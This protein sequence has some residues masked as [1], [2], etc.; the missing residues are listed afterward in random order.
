M[1]DDLP[2]SE[3]VVRSIVNE[4]LKEMGRKPEAK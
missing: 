1:S 4:V 3:F 2:N